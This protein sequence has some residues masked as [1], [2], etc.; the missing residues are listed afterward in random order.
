MKE[1]IMKNKGVDM[2]CG[3]GGI[4]TGLKLALAELGLPL[5]LVAINH[6]TIAIR[7]HSINHPDVQHVCDDIENADPLFLVPGGHLLIL[8][9]AP[10]CVHFSNARGGKPMSDQSRASAG[11]VLRW[12]RTLHIENLLIENVEEFTN[13]GPLYPD[14]YAE[15][16]LRGRPVPERK[17]EFFQAFL[18]DLGEIGYTLDWRILNCADYGDATTRKRFFL[19]ARRGPDAAA[20]TW[21]PLTHA[22]RLTAPGKKLKPWVSARE[23][24]DW[25][26]PGKSIYDRKKPLM[27]NT[28]R[29]IYAGLSKFCGLEF[30]IGQQSGAVPRSVDDPI[31]TVASAGAISFVQPYIVVFRNHADSQDVADPLPTVTAGGQHIG[32]AQP[33]LIGME[34]STEGHS[35]RCFS[36]EASLPT[37]TARAGFGLCRPYFVKYHGSHAGQ[38]DGDTRNLS[39]EDP[40]P[41]L[42]TS[43]RVAL[44]QPYAVPVTHGGGAQRTINLMEPLPTITTA[45]RGEMALVQPFLA[46]YYGTGGPLSVDDP[47]NTVTTK[48]RF[49]L[50]DP[51]LVDLVEMEGG[52]IIGYLDIL[53]RML[54]PHELAAAHSFP[55]K[56][57]FFGT[58]DLQV[59]QVGNS[60]P[61]RTAKALCMELLKGTRK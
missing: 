5:E 59:K 45:H 33:Y 24:I 48:D 52:E 47:L 8:A 50:V 11:Y 31:P 6:S 55:T 19:Q 9:A 7:T 36:T 17:G 30:V 27:P 42:D 1:A 44:V 41:T 22:P 26:V 49:A 28:M 12:A 14:D 23:I 56:Y 2:F 46:S 21:P 60:V 16:K 32:L 29:R 34:H 18:T 13:W 57:Y 54:Q 35:R 3:A 61:V 40:V 37:I 4:S 20:I 10:S 43:N 25:S 53:F 58:Q 15:E 38:S 51:R 39:L